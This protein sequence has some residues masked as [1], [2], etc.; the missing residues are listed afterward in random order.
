[1]ARADVTETV[2]DSEIGQDAAANDDIFKQGR[3]DTGQ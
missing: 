1:M 2:N 3:I